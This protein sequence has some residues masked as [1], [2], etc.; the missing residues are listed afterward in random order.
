M[1]TACQYLGYAPA[2]VAV[3]Y[4]GYDDWRARE[5][6]E[7]EWCRQGGVSMSAVTGWL[8]KRRRKAPFLRN[9]TSE[10]L[11][12]KASPIKIALLTTALALTTMG[13]ANAA[14]CLK[15]AVVGGVAGHYAGHHAVV[16]A[17]GG[18]IVGRHLAKQ[19]AQQQAAQRQA[20]QAQ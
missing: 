8:L 19:H 11:R 5:W 7:R 9:T 4:G 2:P 15:G 12:M 18:C 13:T 14:G 1:I 17:V 3:A 20:A 6:R 16:G 10:Y